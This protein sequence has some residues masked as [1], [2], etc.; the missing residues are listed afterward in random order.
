MAL[1]INPASA[2]GVY[3]SLSFRVKTKLIFISALC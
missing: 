3:T 2:N 1:Q